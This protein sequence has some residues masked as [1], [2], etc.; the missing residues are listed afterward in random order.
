MFRKGLLRSLFLFSLALFAVISILAL[1]YTEAATTATATDKEK[2]QYGGTLKVIVAV[3]TVN[4]GYPAAG[5][6]P[7]DYVIAG[8][9]IE[10]LFRLDN[11]ARPVPWLATGYKVSSDMKSV[12]ITLRKGVKFHDGTD[13]NAEAVKYLLDLYRTSAMSELKPVT[14][15]DIVD[16]HTVRLNISE[17]KVQL[18]YNLAFRAGQMVSPTAIKNQG[19]DW[20]MN[21][22]V[23][24]GPF[25]FVSFKRDA[26]VKYEKFLGYWQK[27][28]PYLD[29]VEFELIAD[30]TTAVMAFKSGQGHVFSTGLSAKYLSELK[31]TGKYS[32]TILASNVLTLAG[33]S[34]N[35]KSPFADV[36]VRRA[37][38]HAI[39][40]AAIE[41][42]VGY[43]IY[44]P[45]SQVSAPES[46]F[47]N[48][49]VKG[50][51]YNPQKAKEL[52]AQ[53]G[54][55]NGFKTRIIYQTTDPQDVFTAIQ[56][57]LSQVGI[58]AKLEP[59]TQQLY[60]QTHR[61]GWDNALIYMQVQTGPRLDPG[62]V[63]EGWL[64]SKSPQFV[65]VIHPA[66]YEAKLFP[67]A[68]ELNV[69]KRKELYQTVMKSISDNALVVP[70]Y[71]SRGGAVAYPEVKKLGMYEG[72][73]NLWTPEDTWLSKGKTR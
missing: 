21:N 55:P 68:T 8:P 6:M 56:A 72:T 70:I 32:T 14:S 33:D 63:L 5:Y 67:A 62:N 49:S 17:F 28:K 2:P 71:V 11:Q 66:D 31:E 59:L 3:S 36:R 47:H 34:A 29:G 61:N 16:S 1:G 19:K 54:Y 22:P 37:V 73:V 45:A 24:T 4:L 18:P 43:G 51:E 35:P 9:A 10:T 25:K 38:E 27:G 26:S 65:S 42:A 58:E 13:F 50:Y 41:K 23:G 60:V 30:R 57:Y 53:A 44:T 69:K 48:P 15:I 40:K 20:C 64:S 52:L 39:D 46:W 12:T 7:G